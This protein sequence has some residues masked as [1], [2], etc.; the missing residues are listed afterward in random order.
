MGGVNMSLR[1]P[2][3]GT[4]VPAAKVFWFIRLFSFNCMACNAKL[5]LTG[6]ART[7]LVASVTASVV[8]SYAVKPSMESGTPAIVV[9][10]AGLLASCVLTWKMGKLSL[11]EK[12]ATD[13]KH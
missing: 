12:A 9:F 7:I 2:Q 6:G 13:E 1:C 3:C 10:F 11:L 5:A 4:A 8:I